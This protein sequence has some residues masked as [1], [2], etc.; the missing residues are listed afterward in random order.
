MNDRITSIQFV[1]YTQ[2]SSLT[3]EFEIHWSL[4]VKKTVQKVGNDV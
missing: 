3:V 2:L 4:D 1:L